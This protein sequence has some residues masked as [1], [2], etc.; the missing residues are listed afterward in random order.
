MSDPRIEACLEGGSLA[1]DLGCGGGEWADAVVGRYDRVVGIDISIDRLERRSHPVEAWEFIQADLN[2]GI[3]LPDACADGVHADQVIEHVANPLYFLLEAHRVL[4]T[5]GVLVVATPNVRYIRHVVRLVVGGY[6]P[7][8]SAMAL[9]T[10]DVWDE[11]HIHFLTSR[12][13]EW[14]AHAAGFSRIRTEALIDL[15]GSLRPLRR[16]MNHVRTSGPVKGFLSGNLMLVAT[17]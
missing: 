11:G 4:R 2:H 8:T 7:I 6:G 12:D 9:R 16:L 14:L 15:T 17:K 5:G 1:V 3:P 13:L 10:P